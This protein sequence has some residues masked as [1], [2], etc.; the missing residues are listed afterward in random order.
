MDPFKVDVEAAGGY[1]SNAL[2]GA[3]T[4]PG[5]SGTA[6]ALADIDLRARVAPRVSPSLRPVLEVDIVGHGLTKEAY[7]ELSSLETSARAGALVTL[8]R[9]RTLLGYRAEVLFLNQT[10]S[11]YSEAHRGEI[12]IESA[13]GWVVFGGAGHRAY[14]DERRTRSEW[15]LGIGGPTNL[16]PRTSLLLGATLRGGSALSPA[17]DFF[18]ASLAAAARIGLPGGLSIRLSATASLDDYPHSGGLEGQ[19]AFG[20]AEKRRD[21]LGRAT[22][23]IWLPERRG[24]RIGVEGEFARRDSTADSRPGSDFDYTEMQG[25]VVVRFTFGANPSAPHV[26]RSAGHVPLEWGLDS[27]TDAESERIIDL[28]RQDEELRRGSSCGL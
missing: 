1:T 27:G 16:I 19:I 28:L 25:R 7:R 26:A 21:L 12:E 15:D 14:R 13:R 17:Y 4:D 11:R 5:A 9:Y 23:G 6:S 18:G 24:L 22:V 20:T 8:G 10:P 2:A 3:P